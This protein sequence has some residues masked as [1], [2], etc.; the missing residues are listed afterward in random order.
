MVFRFAF[1]LLVCGTAALGFQGQAS[2]P[3]SEREKDVYV[4]YSLML[5][6][7]ETSHGPD[8]NERY[9]IA[10]TTAVGVPPGAM[11]LPTERA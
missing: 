10:A 5:T 9:L 1:L 7:P 6:N 11:Y 3:D 4:I 2:S 8:N